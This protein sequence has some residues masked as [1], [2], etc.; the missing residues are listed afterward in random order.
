LKTKILN[1]LVLITSLFG[2]LEWGQDQSQFLFEAEADIFQKL[3]TNP[4]SVVHPFILL[5]L[6][7][8]LLLLITLFQKTPSRLL[9]WCGVGSLALLLGFMFLIGLMT[10]NYRIVLSTLPF[11]TLGILA[12]RSVAQ[13]QKT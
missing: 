11:V 12:A 4:G 9:T 1:S 10:M 2:Y 8:Q 7:G 3:F 5:P 6:A 13:K